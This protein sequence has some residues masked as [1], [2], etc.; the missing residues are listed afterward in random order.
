[1]KVVNSKKSG[2]IKRFVSLAVTA[3][4]TAGIM[5]PANASAFSED[6]IFVSHFDDF[7]GWTSEQ[8][9]VTD[10]PEGFF[11]LDGANHPGRATTTGSIVDTETNSRSFMLK[12]GAMVCYQFDQ[13]YKTGSRRISFDVKM[14]KP[15]S[16][17]FWVNGHRADNDNP[18]DYWLD[19]PMDDNGG[20]RWDARPYFAINKDSVRSVNSDWGAIESKNTIADNK[21][22]KVEILFDYDKNTITHFV[23]GEK[24]SQETAGS[25]N[26]TV[27][28]NNETDKTVYI[29]NF[30]VYHG[31]N[32]DYANGVMMKLDG[33][34]GAVV[35]SGHLKVELSR[36]V[37]D[38]IT[39]S[40]FTVKDSDGDIVDS[41]VTAVSKTTARATT[42]DLTMGDLQKGVYTLQSS[43]IANTIEFAVANTSVDNIDKEVYTY[44]QEDFNSYTGGV[45]AQ[46]QAT[47]SNTG[48]P[49]LATDTD[50]GNTLKFA[51]DSVTS[52]M[53]KLDETFVSGKLKVEFDMK[54]SGKGW[55]IGFIREADWQDA[56]YE[57]H[58]V[59]GNI[60]DNSNANEIYTCSKS[61][62]PGLNSKANATISNNDWNHVVIT[63]NMTNEKYEFDVNGTNF[64]ASHP[65]HV[66]YKTLWYDVIKSTN[67]ELTGQ[68]LFKCGLNGIRLY[69]DGTADVQFDNIKM[70]AENSDNLTEDFDDFTNE[71]TNPNNGNL[72]YYGLPAG[73]FRRNDIK[74][75]IASFNHALQGCNYNETTNPGDKGATVGGYEE[76]TRVRLTHPITNL[77]NNAV[78]IEFDA[79]PGDRFQI[80]FYPKEKFYGD[81]SKDTGS[82]FHSHTDNGVTYAD[83]YE[84]AVL[85]IGTMD[86]NKVLSYVRGRWAESTAFADNKEDKF[87]MSDGNWNHVKVIFDAVNG[88]TAYL[89]D[90][91]KQMV[92]TT[93]E[94]KNVYNYNKILN[95]WNNVFGLGLYTLNGNSI[96]IDN[97]KVYSVST[98]TKPEVISVST[99]NIDD[100]KTILNGDTVQVSNLAKGIELKFTEALNETAETLADKIKL[101]KNDGTTMNVTRVLSNDKMTYTLTFVD[102]PATGTSV[103]LKSSYDIKGTTSVSALANPVSKAINFVGGTGEVAVNDMQLY[104]K[105]LG[106][107]LG[108]N[109]SSK[110]VWVP[111]TTRSDKDAAAYK[112]VIS[113]T[114]TTGAQDDK[115]YNYIEGIYNTSNDTE[116]LGTVN[117]NKLVI[118][119]KIEYTIEKELPA[120]SDS[121]NQTWRT[122]IW[123]ADQTPAAD[124]LK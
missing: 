66:K 30:A 36:Y 67:T 27:Y 37:S 65:Y 107:D 15:T 52:Y 124:A 111:A 86:S 8:G 16:G 55:G 94:T 14:E 101:Y 87:V 41:A 42:L 121:E 118:P 57:K 120:L 19:Q 29:D 80:A 44:Y 45:P 1:M 76:Q 48:T 75:P 78:A 24:L 109:R 102:A 62:N 100:T 117:M 22:H 21:W 28:F 64:S 122:F 13:V 119:A 99:V 56:D 123:A 96:D 32:P 47:V 7:S 9:S 113:G 2:K 40:D 49:A 97:L 103:T 79:K 3:V 46:W 38:N 6:K 73:Y 106:R 18:Y 72:D 63:V 110:D 58:L 12:S 89:N 95:N 108:S 33:D 83:I 105:V 81:G 68:D 51:K 43:K 85:Q 71:Y 10:L 116:I 90:G 115:T 35:L 112:I 20:I 31:T 61:E 26:K 77:K 69:S 25:K 93:V 98:V 59:M 74:N 34:N 104:K 92:S 84:D 23:D 82:T 114:N 17:N 60:A 88:V 54:T 50:K 39:A 4:M 11:A 91:E 5:L 70:Y 53:H